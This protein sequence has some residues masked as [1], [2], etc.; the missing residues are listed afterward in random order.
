MILLDL[1]QI[2]I[3][4]LM[5]Y[6]HSNNIGTPEEK[7][8]FMVDAGEDANIEASF[9]L[10]RHMVLNSIRMYRKKFG[11]KYGEIV[12]CSDGRKYWRQKKFTQYKASR[13]TTRQ[14]SNVDWT[15][16][17]LVINQIKEELR[18]IFPYKL[19]E[20]DTAEAD[21]VIAIIVK[22]IVED[23]FGNFEKVLIVSADKDFIQLQKFSSVDQYNPIA[24]KFIGPPDKI[25]P[26]KFLHQLIMK[27]DR[28]D[29]IPNF[30]SED[31]SFTTGKRQTA[32]SKK[33]LK[34]WG[35]YSSKAF[36]DSGL[37]NE[38]LL[39]NY[40]RNQML[41][42][43]DFIPENLVSKI[44]EEYEKPIPGNRSKILDYFIEKK[45]K[46]LTDSIGDF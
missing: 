24:K 39:R 33:K 30:L 35:D 36:C 14:A 11:E 44:I 19:I 15:V 25:L 31:D 21:D 28:S 34:T 3:S 5:M 6:L 17:F 10:V 37:V 1:N 26:Q 32:L 27:G 7:E 16:V 20:V 12:L 23:S 22:D 13:K 41:I 43:F 8:C 38:T 9:G 46:D 4:N 42:D 45:L 18:E 29:G 40:K 2:M